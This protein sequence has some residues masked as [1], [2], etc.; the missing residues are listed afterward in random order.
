MDLTPKPVQDEAPAVIAAAPDIVPKDP[1]AKPETKKGPSKRLD[2]L[3][4][5]AVSRA[6]SGAPREALNAAAEGLRIDA[7]DP[8]L[9]NLVATLLRDA[10]AGARR[11]REEAAQSDAELNAPEEFQQGVNRER[12]AVRL[13]RSGKL[14]AATRGFWGAADLFSAARTESRDV[15]KEAKAAAERNS[16]V[17]RRQ[18]PDRQRRRRHPVQPMMNAQTPKSRRSIRRCVDTKPPTRA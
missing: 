17:R 6:Q 10:Q 7:R 18:P 15:A 12:D 4:T 2:D 11:A 5:V 3:R 16:A 8:V 14:E 9:T 13:Q 1:V